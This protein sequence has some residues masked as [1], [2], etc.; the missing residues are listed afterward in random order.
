MMNGKHI[1]AACVVLIAVVAIG[2]GAFLNSNMDMDTP[3]TPS[4]PDVPDAPDIPVT[5]SED[6]ILVVYFSKTG[7]LRPRHSA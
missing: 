6:N 2:A 3:S 4:E 1:I 5:P 7:P